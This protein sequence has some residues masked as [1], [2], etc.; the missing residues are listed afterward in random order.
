MNDTEK[1]AKIRDILKPRLPPPAELCV[2]G[3]H[4]CSLSFCVSPEWPGDARL[5]LGSYAG[6]RQLHLSPESLD[7]IAAWIRVFKEHHA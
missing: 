6:S 2:P 5:T 3:T 7:S 4:G 1:L